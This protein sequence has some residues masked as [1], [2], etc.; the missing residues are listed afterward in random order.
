MPSQ[1]NVVSNKPQDKTVYHITTL[2]IHASV[3]VD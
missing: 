1:S 2:Q 3:Q